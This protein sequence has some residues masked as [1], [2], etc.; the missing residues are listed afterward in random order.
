M[1]ILSRQEAADLI[2]RRIGKAHREHLVVLSLDTHKKLI[3]MDT[4]SVGTLDAL[5]VHPRETFL[6]AIKRHAS[7]VIIAHNHPSGELEPSE[8]DLVVC[9]RLATAGRILGIEVEDSI[10]VG[11]DGYLSL[12][13]KGVI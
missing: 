13:E 8:N 7:S 10:I 9:K 3:A 5:L 1:S 12:R 6:P 11:R 4:V 2:I